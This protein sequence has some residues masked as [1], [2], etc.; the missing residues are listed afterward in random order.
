MPGRA[1]RQGCGLGRGVP[2]GYEFLKQ[3]PKQ[4]GNVATGELCHCQTE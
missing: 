2:Y 1:G 3:G 4:F